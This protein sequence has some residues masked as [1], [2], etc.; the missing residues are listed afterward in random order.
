MTSMRFDFSDVIV[1]TN[2]IFFIPG[3]PGFYTLIKKCCF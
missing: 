1:I 3:D 2:I